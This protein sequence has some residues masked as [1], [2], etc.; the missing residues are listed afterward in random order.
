ME[1][2]LKLKEASFRKGDGMFIGLAQM[3]IAWEDESINIKKCEE[4]IKKASCKKVELLLFPEMTLTG[5]TM[6]IEKLNLSE[7]EIFNWLKEKCINY[8]INIGLGYAIKIDEKGQ[9][10]YVI[11]SNKGEVILNYSKIHPFS[12]AKE[13][14][15]YYK[16]NEIVSC[17]IDEFNISSFIC[18]DLRFPEIFQKASEN[19]HL[20][21]V[22]AN[23][24][25][26]R[27]SHWNAL[28]KARAIENQC[29]IAAINRVGTSDGL[30]YTGESQVI[31]PNGE[32]ITLLSSKEELIVCK[33]ELGNVFK[34]RD[35]I[36][37]KKDR[38]EELYYQSNFY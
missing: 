13:D 24:P 26:L 15:K 14:E 9:N 31:D 28:L 20:I 6:N 25:G 19:A 27:S 18:Y 33:I 36:S 8:N 38:R 3:D 34:I 5:F 32:V 1:V 17:Q 35:N 21:T 7:E 22:A 12:K 37:V 23:W 29:Y 16:G 10:K 2:R 30:E 4:F 11:I